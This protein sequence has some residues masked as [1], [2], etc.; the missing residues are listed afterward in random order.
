MHIVVIKREVVRKN[1]WVPR[2][3]YQ[4]FTEAKRRHDEYYRSI[5]S[6]MHRVLTLCWATELYAENRKLMGEDAWPYGVA[7]NRKTLE[8]ALRYH[9]EQGMS[10]RRFAIEEIF[11]PGTLDD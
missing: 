10:K 6:K 5:A 11:A 7:A 3:L 4:A 8:T 9:H 1:P 2:A